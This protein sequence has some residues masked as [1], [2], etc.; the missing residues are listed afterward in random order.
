M[1]AAKCYCRPQRDPVPRWTCYDASTAQMLCCLSATV[2][3]VRCLEA[4]LSPGDVIG[5]DQNGEQLINCPETG[6]NTHLRGKAFFWFPDANATD[7]INPWRPC[8]QVC[9]ESQLPGGIITN[10]LTGVQVAWNYSCDTGLVTFVSTWI[11]APGGT[12]PSFLTFPSVG[13]V[14]ADPDWYLNNEIDIPYLTTGVNNNRPRFSVKLKMTCDARDPCSPFTCWPVCMA[15]V[16]D[17]VTYVKDIYFS[18]SGCECL[19][20]DSELASFGGADIQFRFGSSEAAPRP[21]AYV[22]VQYYCNYVGSLIRSVS[23]Q[24]RIAGITTYTD[25]VSTDCVEEEWTDSFTLDP[26]AFQDPNCTST[27]TVDVTSGGG[28]RTP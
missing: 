27:V 26:A 13:I 19:N 9:S 17:G 16:C 25:I 20:V 10:C 1:P 2:Y 8:P 28:W 22:E 15:K 14:T 24:G 12:P 5:I 11:F 18:V 6:A 23:I 7:Q 21:C 3:D 4:S